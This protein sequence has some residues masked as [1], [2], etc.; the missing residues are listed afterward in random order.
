MYGNNYLMFESEVERLK[1][2]F[3]MEAEDDDLEESTPKDDKPADDDK[4]SDDNK[5]SEDESSENKGDS[6]PE[7]PDKESKEN[8][9][10]SSGDGFEELDD[11]NGETGGETE[12]FDLDRDMPD[13]TGGLGEP[14]NG[15]DVNANNGTPGAITPERLIAEITSGQDNIYTRVINEVKPKFPN[16]ECQVKDLLE[17]IAHAIS[18]YLKNKKYAG[19][20]TRTLEKKNP[21]KAMNQENAIHL[22]SLVI[23]KNIKDGKF[24]NYA[25]RQQQQAQSAPKTES[26]RMGYRSVRPIEEQTLMEGWKDILLA[27]G[28]AANG[29]MGATAQSAPVS[30]LQGTPRYQAM[31]QQANTPQ[32]KQQAPQK[33]SGVTSGATAAPSTSSTGV[34]F[35][36]DSTYQLSPQQFQQFQASGNLPKH[37]I[38]ASD[39][40]AG[41]NVTKVPQSGSQKPSNKGYGKNTG[42]GNV[43]ATQG[44]SVTQA[45][46][47]EQAKSGQTT[48]QI[49]TGKDERCVNPDEQ[50]GNFGKT[51]HELGHKG[52]DL[53]YKGGSALWGGLKGAAKGLWD[54]AKKN[55][56]EAEKD[57]EKDHD[58]MIKERKASKK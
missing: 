5:K 26:V 42:N 17:P 24:I 36:P 8:S 12:D 45:A 41:Q 54:G 27:G 15:G 13:I 32:Q 55:W 20:D 4:K 53:A 18:A 7:D 52:V 6:K 35:S 14:Q 40:Q 28:I 38:V 49:A 47:K 22:I 23:A 3:L 31:Q 39:A 10:D 57:L 16:G 48:K 58:E 30:T 56:G 44:S 25:E 43:K 29:V 9:G 37:Y 46:V 11:A 2:L 21:N 51:V 19:I 34:Q 50:S 33:K 1:P